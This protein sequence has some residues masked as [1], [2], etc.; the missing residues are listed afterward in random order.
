[1]NAV[2]PAVGH[3]AVDGDELIEPQ[4]KI[5]AV[6]ALH[7]EVGPE[8]RRVPCDRGVARHQE[9]DDDIDVGSAVARRHGAHKL[10][11]GQML[12]LVVALLQERLDKLRV[13]AIA[14]GFR[15]QTQIHVQ[16]SD[17]WHIGFAQQQ[18]GNGATDHGELALVA[19]E[20]LTDLDQH[21]SDHDRGASS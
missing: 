10:K 14:Q 15:I 2:A 12:P 13:L 1:M 19:S 8:R 17:M 16:G 7:G 18:P 3:I 6:G 20:D 21:R 11:A 9:I 4:G 5:G